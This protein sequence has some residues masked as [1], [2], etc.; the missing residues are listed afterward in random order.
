MT[1]SFHHRDNRIEQNLEIRF[2]PVGRSRSNRSGKMPPGRRAH[3]PHIIAIDF[4]SLRMPA[5]KFQGILCIR[6]GNIGVTAR[7]TILQDYGSNPLTLE[8]FSPIVT[9][10]PDGEPYKASSRTNHYGTACCHLLFWKIYTYLR[11]IVSVAANIRRTSIIKF[12]IESTLGTG[13]NNRQCQAKHHK[14]LV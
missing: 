7:K 10:M 6:N 12:Q 3:N 5:H 8:K 4:P 2:C 1:I 13:R 14:E 9:F 11:S